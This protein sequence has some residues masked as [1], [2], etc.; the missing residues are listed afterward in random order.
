MLDIIIRFNLIGR[1]VCKLFITE[2]DFNFIFV[3]DFNR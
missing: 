1:F 3:I 2:L